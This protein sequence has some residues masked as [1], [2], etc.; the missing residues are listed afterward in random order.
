MNTV[1]I[2]SLAQ[3]VK[4]V[5]VLQNSIYCWLKKEPRDRG[6]LAQVSPFIWYSP[7]WRV[8]LS[9]LKQCLAV[10]FVE[11]GRSIW[12]TSCWAEGRSVR[13]WAVFVISQPIF[14][15]FFF[16]LFIYFLLESA[17]K[18]NSIHSI[19]VFKTRIL[20]WTAEKNEEMFLKYLV[21]GWV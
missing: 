8:I 20:I 16:Y 13:H 18:G 14:N 2:R 15:R 10:I 6:N 21:F 9:T 5:D 4:W 7:E 17:R 3:S 11:T 19:H 1:K 12:T